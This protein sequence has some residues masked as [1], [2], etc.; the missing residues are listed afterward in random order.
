[1]LKQELQSLCEQRP[2]AAAA[3]AAACKGAKKPAFSKK[4]G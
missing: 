2:A 3:A 1:M 4:K